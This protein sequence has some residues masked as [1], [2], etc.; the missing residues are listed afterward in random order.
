VS[1]L[2]NVSG[3][4]AQLNETNGSIQVWSESSAAAITLADTSGI[5][6]ALGMAAGAYQGTPGRSQSSITRTG[7]RTVSNAGEVAESAAAALDGFNQALAEI[8]KGR[9]S[10]AEFQRKLKD[11]LTDAVDRLRDAG[12]RGLEVTDDALQPSLSASSTDMVNALKALADDTELGRA[13]APTFERF[14]ADVASAAGWDAPAP[15]AVQRLTLADTSRAQL[16]ADQTATTLLFL[17]SSLQP[18][19]S[20]ETS[21]KSAMKAYGETP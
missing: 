21:Q 13:L 4:G 8:T 1:A 16:L 9:E 11:A 15:A 10:N 18:H 14:S 5:L 19:E 3:V 7:D 20:E 6:T 12:I 2:N 17:R